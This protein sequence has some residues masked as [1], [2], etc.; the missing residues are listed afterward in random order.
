MVIRCEIQC[1]LL[2]AII[3]N[4][5]IIQQKFNSYTTRKII[6]VYN[7]VF[8]RKINDFRQNLNLKF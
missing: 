8:L 5:S 1:Y 3:I 2:L 7:Q 4:L 6:N